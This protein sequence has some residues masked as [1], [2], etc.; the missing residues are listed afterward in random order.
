MTPNEKI[1]DAFDRELNAVMSVLKE[2]RLLA[3]V[4]SK[5]LQIMKRYI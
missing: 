3:R 1:V 2:S 5:L 4:D